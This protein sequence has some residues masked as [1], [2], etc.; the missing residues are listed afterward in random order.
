LST[1]RCTAPFAISGQRATLP[2][3]GRSAPAPGEGT[4][5]CATLGSTRPNNTC[6]KGEI[7][8]SEAPLI[9]PNTNIQN[10]AAA[11]RRR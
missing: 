7:I 4:P 2:N 3:V 8:P 6:M 9:A 1:V 5:T 10:I 11:R